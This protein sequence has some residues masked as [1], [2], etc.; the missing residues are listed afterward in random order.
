MHYSFQL[1]TSTGT[2]LPVC[3][4]Q[5]AWRAMLYH[6]QPRLKA[7]LATRR[8]TKEFLTRVGMDRHL[9]TFD[10]LRISYEE[11]LTLRTYFLRLESLGTF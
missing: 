2:Y 10:R 4:M 8:K 1:S 7:Y 3:I 9:P 11:M 5:G 6:R